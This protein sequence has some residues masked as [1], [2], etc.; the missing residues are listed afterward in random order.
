MGSAQVDILGCIII[1]LQAFF[2]IALT[3]LITWILVTVFDLLLGNRSDD[4][5]RD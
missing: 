3:L 2:L 1:I 5:L 4:T